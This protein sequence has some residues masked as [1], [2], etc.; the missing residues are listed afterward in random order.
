MLLP[1]L[2]GV[3]TA[4]AGLLALSAWAER[5]LL[6]PDAHYPRPPVPAAAPGTRRLVCAG[7]SL[8]HGNM[9]ASYVAPLAARLAP[10][11]VEVLNAGINADLTHTLLR[12]LDDVVAARPDFVSLLIGTN[13]VN[14]TLG[15]GQLRHYRR[16]GKLTPAEQPSPEAYRQNLT[17]LLR[18]LR[19]E[20]TARVAVLSLPPLGEDLHHEAN[21]RADHY[22]AIIREVAQAEGATYLSLRER[23][24]ELLHQQPSHPRVRFEQTTRLIRLAVVQH[25]GLGQSWDQI[26]AGHGCRFLTDNLHLNTAGAAVIEELIAGWVEQQLGA[27]EARG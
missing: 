24:Q 8:T 11:G 9:S 27:R 13:D 5:R 21:R 20:T 17:Q 10:A 19:Q 7:D 15:P 18:R 3:G 16:L 6:R 14:A 25:Y 23:L 22:C 2:L 26:A 12:R 1:I 4:G